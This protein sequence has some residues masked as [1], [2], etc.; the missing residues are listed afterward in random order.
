MAKNKPYTPK[1]FNSIREMMDMAVADVPEKLAYRYKTEDDEIVNV[2]YTSFYQRTQNLGAALTELGYGNAHIAC[3]AENSYSWIVSYLTVL[4]SAGVFVPVDKDLPTAEMLY[5]LN[6]S[7]ASAV[8]FDAKHEAWFREHRM[9]MPS[10]KL[11]INLDGKTDDGEF[12]SFSGLVEMGKRLD[13][14]AFKALRSDEQDMKLLVY[15]SGTTGV[16][17][18][19]MLTERNLVASVY[20][21]L[22]VSSISEVGL[23]VLPYNHTYAAVCEILVGIHYHTTLCLNDNLKNIRK[24]MQLFKPEYM[25][26]VPAHAEAFYNN[27]KKTIEKQSKTKTFEKG[28]KLSNALRKIGIDRR[29]DLFKDV[30]AAF[31]GNLRRFVC[32][33]API[34]PEMVQFFDSIG[35]NL[36]CGYG[37]TECSPLVSVNTEAEN[38]AF[39]VGH[40]L[41]C[42][43]WRIDD[44]SEEGIGEICVKGDVVMKGYYKAPDKTAEAIIDGWFYTGDYGKLTKDD[45]LM[46]TGRKKNIIILGNG[47]NIYPEEIEGYIQ[48]IDYVEE[49]VVRG[50]KSDKG[51]ETGLLAEIYS[52]EQK[53][54]E[55]VISDVKKALSPLPSY[56]HISK[57]V[58]RTEPFEKTT[59]RKIKR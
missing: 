5:I 48:N 7:D 53:T 52:Q 43:E 31:G 13:K 58:M 34:R 42:L 30:H 10:I 39:T 21:G 27:V 16:A 40:R 8:F 50:I 32:G 18:G 46:I 14:S 37:I 11:F 47:K 25:Y 22:C 12:V 41:P 44:P 28:V 20:Y 29:R 56:K 35:I 2:T 1:K 57:I 24:N 33:G 3:V 38:N 6:N 45:T 36:S 54:A 15:T 17:K 55:E 49:V 4:Q 23:S 26:V 19:V 9:E 51:T 59:T